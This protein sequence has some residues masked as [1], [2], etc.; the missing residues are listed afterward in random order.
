M[1][2]AEYYNKFSE[3]FYK[4][5]D[6][7]RESEVKTLLDLIKYDTELNTDYAKQ[8]TNR[9]IEEGK[10]PNYGGLID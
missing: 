10:I 1:K 6:K 5:G 2:I 9:L 4:C 7:V 8:I 3:E